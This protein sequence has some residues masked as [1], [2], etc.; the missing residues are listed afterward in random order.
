MDI[1]ALVWNAHRVYGK[2]RL[3]L[4]FNNF[5]ELSWIGYNKEQLLNLPLRSN[6]CQPV[7]VLQKQ[8]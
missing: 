8:K 6:G 5:K 1:D 3:P 4:L 7:V 2:I